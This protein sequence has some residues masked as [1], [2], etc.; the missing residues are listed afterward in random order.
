MR[1]EFRTEVRGYELVL[2]QDLF[3]AFILYR[4]W[5]GLNNHRGG[6]KQQVFEDEMDAL[7]EVKSI[8]HTREKHGYK[9]IVRS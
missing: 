2:N 8:R 9:L 5:F 7:R 1:L 4:R 6:I 3:G